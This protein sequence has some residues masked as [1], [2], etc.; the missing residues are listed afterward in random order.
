MTEEVDETKETRQILF[1]AMNSVYRGV[2]GF[3]VL[4]S[5]TCESLRQRR[6]LFNVYEIRNDTSRPLESTESGRSGRGVC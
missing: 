2:H 6:I 3:D 4:K 5:S 1:S